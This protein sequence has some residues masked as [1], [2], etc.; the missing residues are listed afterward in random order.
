MPPVKPFQPMDPDEAFALLEGH[1]CTLDDDFAAVDTL[2]ERLRCPKCGSKME[3]VVNTRQP[4]VEGQVVPNF[5]ARCTTCQLTMTQNEIIIDRGGIPKEG[6]N[7]NEG[8]SPL[9][10]RNTFD[11]H[12]AA[13][14]YRRVTGSHLVRPDE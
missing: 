13:E 2:F 3:K 6:P 14:Q 7:P 12:Q 4:F 8:M 9:D 1:Q 10:P 5:L 11:P